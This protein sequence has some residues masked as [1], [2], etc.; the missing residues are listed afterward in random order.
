MKKKKSLIPS[1][2]E[3]SKIVSEN[4]IPENAKY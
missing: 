2:L 4:N 3:L 1:F